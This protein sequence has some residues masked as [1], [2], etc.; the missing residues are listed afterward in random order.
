MS[1]TLRQ[2][3][4]ALKKQLQNV[5]QSKGEGVVGIMAGS[6]K[7][8]KT[9]M[10]PG[11]E[12]DPDKLHQRLKESFKEQIGL[13]REGVYLMT[14][15][16]IDMLPGVDRPT[17]R[18]RSMYASREED[19]LMLKWP[20]LREGEAVTSLDLLGTEWAKIL[21]QSPSM[22]YIIKFH[23]LPAFLASVQLAEFEKQTM[24]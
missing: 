14:G 11:S 3:N 7:K 13:F 1:D 6:A 10:T 21:S 18:V 8:T 17:F 5:L 2:Q 4:A 24:L 23:S 12:V 16:K 19:H 22:D 15:Y 9:A 20:K